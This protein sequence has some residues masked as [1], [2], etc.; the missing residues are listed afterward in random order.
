MDQFERDLIE[1]ASRHTIDDHDNCLFIIKGDCHKKYLIENISVP[2]I[3]YFDEIDC[4][5]EKL[6][7]VLNNLQY[8]SLGYF[9]NRILPRIVIAIFQIPQHIFDKIH[10]RL[11]QKYMN[12]DAVENDVKYL[13]LWI[14]HFWNAL[15]KHKCAD[16][17]KTQTQLRLPRLNAAESIGVILDLLLYSLEELFDIKFKRMKYDMVHT[18][19][20][21]TQFESLPTHFTELQRMLNHKLPRMLYRIIPL[22]PRTNAGQISSILTA[23][24]KS[25]ALSCSVFQIWKAQLD[26][27]SL[28]YTWKQQ[29]N[30]S[31]PATIIISTWLLDEDSGFTAMLQRVAGN[32]TIIQREI[33]NMNKTKDL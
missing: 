24:E 7:D 6:V 8:P 13:Y 15:Q 5:F 19:C 33:V 10:A 1:S 22:D 26:M 20:S 31:E 2:I 21:F 11:K 25:I 12:V 9:G 29:R 30:S 32:D 4:A 17:A 27:L 18:Y 16:D 28:L 3:T 23:V 14:R